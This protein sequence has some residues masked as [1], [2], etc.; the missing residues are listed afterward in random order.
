MV[1]K[2]IFEQAGYLH[3]LDPGKY[4]IRKLTVGIATDLLELRS[5]YVKGGSYIRGAHVSPSG[6]RAVFDFRG[7]IITVPAE[8]GDPRNLTNTTGVHEKYP[9]WSPDGKSIAYFS[10]ASGEYKLHIKSQDGKGE[11]KVYWSHRHRFLR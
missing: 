10:D 11:A 4:I 9:V 3:T 1:K 7:D 6:A 8:K 5:R 2:I